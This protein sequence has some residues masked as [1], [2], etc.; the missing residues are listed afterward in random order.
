MAIIPIIALAA[1]LTLSG[2]FGIY[3]MQQASSLASS[4]EE[5]QNSLK[6]LQ[7]Q[8]EEKD[9]QIDELS[10]HVSDL[11]SEKESWK[12]QFQEAQTT[13]GVLQDNY[14]SLQ[15]NYFKLQSENKSLKLS[16]SVFQNLANSEKERRQNAEAELAISARPPYTIIQG[17]QVSWVFQDSRGNSYDWEMPIDSYRSLIESAE[18]K[19]YLKLQK[20]DGAAFKVRDHTKFVESRSF[21][22][23]IDGVYDKAESDQQFLYELWYITSQLTIYSTDIGEEPRWALETFTEAGGDCEDLTILIAS[24]L[25]ASSHTS[26]WEIKMVYLDADNPGNPQDVDHVVLYVKTA[27]FTTFVESTTKNDGLNTWKGTING[28]YFDL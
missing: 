14:D 9:N 11:Q 12:V 3:Q 27:D 23:V 4:I 2:I 6:A 22:K 17:R 20:D 16:E 8:A 5:A 28:W 18:P 24:M 13:I 21:A 19:D 10:Q 15:S 1:G 26:D 7:S 25:K